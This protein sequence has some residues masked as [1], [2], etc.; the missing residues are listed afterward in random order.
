MLLTKEI[1]RDDSFQRI[2]KIFYNE[3]DQIIGTLETFKGKEEGD[4][5]GRLDVHE[6]TDESY[7]LIQ[8]KNDTKAYAH[9]T[10]QGHKVLGKN[11]WYSIEEAA[12]VQ[13]FKY[14][15][16]LLLAR[17]C[18]S[19]DGTTYSY[20]YTYQNGVKVS[21]KSVAVDGTVTK[22]NYTYQGKTVLSQST[23]INDRFSD[24][25]NYRYD[26]N[27]L[28]V[29][30][31]KFLKHG[32]SLFLSTQKNFF[33]NAKKEL[34][35]TEHHGRYDGKMYLYKVEETIRK[36][37]ERNIKLYLIPEVEMV[38]GQ[39]DMASMHDYMKRSHMEFAI[40]IFNKEY[41]TKTKLQLLGHNTETVDEQGKVI[42]SKVINP[43]N[44]EE[45]GKVLYR[46]EYNE[47]SLLEFVICYR[48]LENGKAEESSIEKYYYKE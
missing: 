38:I 32:E 25:I 21:E 31:Q 46:N 5:F 8:Y 35:K 12:S 7:R 15:N 47:K 9:F 26:Q 34:E 16:G 6:Y 13:D 22:I 41:I 43:E 48:V 33:Y 23:I 14:E 1:Y 19:E 2:K 24:Q 39:Y 11:G 17:N 42:E 29:E 20:H 44:N 30:E 27:G 37:N 45:I 4:E 28:L 40:P 18:R 36:G 10:S 3:K